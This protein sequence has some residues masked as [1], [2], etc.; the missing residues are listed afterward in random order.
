[1]YV[2]VQ[3]VILRSMTIYSHAKFSNKMSICNSVKKGRSPQQYSLKEVAPYTLEKV[4]TWPQKFVKVA[5]NVKKHEN[6]LLPG[7]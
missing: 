4:S 6:S 7:Q 5:K 2:M 1:M 3:A